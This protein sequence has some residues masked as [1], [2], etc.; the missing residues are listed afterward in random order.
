MFLVKSKYW[1]KRAYSNLNMTCVTRVNKTKYFEG[2][3]IESSY[4]FNVSSHLRIPLSNT[5]SYPI[6]LIMHL[7]S[8]PM[9]S[10]L[11]VLTEIEPCT[12]PQIKPALFSVYRQGN[13][14]G[15][16]GVSNRAAYCQLPHAELSDRG[17]ETPIAAYE[18]LPPN[19]VYAVHASIEMRSLAEAQS[20]NYRS[21]RQTEPR[22]P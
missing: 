22:C 7:S 6:C 11:A 16:A 14:T 9:S 1:P 4:A 2:N 8:L 15:A 18:K 10:I 12:P 17:D 3:C 13:R 5:L 21:L 19:N 20:N